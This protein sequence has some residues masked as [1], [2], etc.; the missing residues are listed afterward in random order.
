MG[1]TLALYGSTG[2]GKTTQLGEY[3]KYI[4]RTSGKLALLNTADQGGYESLMPLVRAGIIIVN[5]LGES[6]D[7][8][9]WVSDAVSKPVPDNIGL[10]A[11]DS[12]TGIGDALL[13]SAA[14]YAAKG[15]Q[16]GSEKKYSIKIPGTSIEIGAN[17][18]SQ[19]G[20]IQRFLLDQIWKSTWL[21]KRQGIDIV[22]TFSESR[23]EDPTD[24]PVVG[25]KLVGKALSGTLP[26]EIKYTLRLVTVPGTGDTPAR[27]LLLTQEREE[28]AGM[29]MSFAN[30]RYPL[31]ATTPL[32]PFIEP[33]SLV[34]FWELIDTA[35]AEAEANILAAL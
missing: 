6:Q 21:A 13:S 14:A 22:W 34:S 30:A 3:A 2:S 15:V 9:S 24:A 11:Y 8:W 17:N 10:V 26:K 18:K 31:D 33:A 28:L 32:P 12:G 23:A 29:G 27:H 16:V 19:Y 20:L 5:E 7:P 35:Q 25:P 1:R 4:K